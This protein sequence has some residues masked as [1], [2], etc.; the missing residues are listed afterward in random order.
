MNFP[1][2]WSLVA[3]MA[4]WLAANGAA[5]FAGYCMGRATPPRPST[6]RST[7]ARVEVIREDGSRVTAVA[8]NRVNMP[9][10]V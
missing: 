7:T 1:F 8:S 6:P 9:E 10:A 2:E 5:A 3:H 4:V